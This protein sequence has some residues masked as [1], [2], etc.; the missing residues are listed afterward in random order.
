MKKYEEV[1]HSFEREEDS[2]F[3]LVK[4]IPAVFKVLGVTITEQEIVDL[5]GDRVSKDA[6]PLV[7][8]KIDFADFLALFVTSLITSDIERQRNSH[9]GGTD[10]SIQNF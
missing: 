10:G 9:E 5:L 4:D 7:S 3:V 8:S 6:N 2:G 1:F